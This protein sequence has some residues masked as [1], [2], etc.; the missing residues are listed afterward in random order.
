M[1]AADRVKARFIG[2]TM[3]DVSPRGLRLTTLREDLNTGHQRVL[4]DDPARLDQRHQHVKGAP[5]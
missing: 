1:I 3:V 2:L 5:A 4:A